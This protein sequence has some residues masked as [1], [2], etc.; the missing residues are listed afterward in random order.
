MNCKPLVLPAV[1]GLLV[2]VL[3]AC[4]AGSDTA[5]SD[6]PIV[7]G[8]TDQIS[9]TGTAPAPLDPAQAYEV[10]QWNM[11]RSTLQT[12]LRMPRSGSTPQPEA[13]QY[14]GFSDTANEQ[15]RCTLRDGLTFS[16]GDPL[17]SRDV[18][19]SVE[20]VARINYANGP[21]SLL[22]NVEAMDTPDARHIVFHLKRP[23]ATF[24]LK[25]STPAAAIVDHQVYPADKFLNGY[26]VVGSGPYTLKTTTRNGTLTGATFVRNPDY[27]GGLKP[28]NSSVQM[29]F[30]DTSSQ[31]E[32][33]LRKGDID[34]TNRVLTPEQV[35]KLQADGEDSG[36]TVQEAP[37]QEIRYLAFDTDAAPVSKKAV[38][39]AMSQVIN[40]GALVDHVYHNTDDPLYSLVPKGVNGHANSFFSKYG[41]PDPDAA[42]KTLRDAH[43]DTPVKLT[44]TYTTRHYGLST[45]REFAELKKQLNGT[46]L[47]RVRTQA[48]D[49][50]Q[51]FR[52]D[53]SKGK[54]AVYGMGWFPD[55]PDAD[56]YLAPFFGKNNFLGSPYRNQRIESELI[57]ASRQKSNR[58]TA[59][60]SLKEVQDIVADDVPVLPLWQGKQYIAARDDITGAEW[61][62]NSS[63]A[64]QIWELGR[65][66][67]S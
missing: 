2:P 63:S 62:L 47:F 35:Q 25:L 28:K 8:T 56:N 60:E 30:Y 31:M 3:S 37:G 44:L 13:A 64:L 53:E 10:S 21:K 39:Q 17:T 40:R 36:I 26:D 66:V 42:R 61:A 65:G 22:D 54:Y 52:S 4:G 6:D 29:K 50:W 41:S 12:L 1:A 32:S 33:A 67:G 45:A 18:K 11:L 23:D 34:V 15:Y 51:K 27:K 43:I 59:G 16:N 24:P 7:V 57:P 48:V 19:Y 20:R 14:C 46:G 5:D 55:F 58:Y 49:D 9:A 38:R